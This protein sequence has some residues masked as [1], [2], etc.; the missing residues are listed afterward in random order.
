MASY[1]TIISVLCL[2]ISI[3]CSCISNSNGRL[4][5]ISFLILSNRIFNIDPDNIKSFYFKIGKYELAHSPF[6]QSIFE[7]NQ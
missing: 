3:K 1:M 2:V 6:S 4:S 7:K 5:K